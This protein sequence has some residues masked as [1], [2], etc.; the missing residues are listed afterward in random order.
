MAGKAKPQG[1]SAAKTTDGFISRKATEEDDVQGHVFHRSRDVVSMK[2]KVV[3]PEGATA[4]RKATEDDDTEGHS[5]LL[6]PTIAHELAKARERDIQK[7]L[8]QH[9]FERD[10]R[11]AKKD[12]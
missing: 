6:H 2:R 11:A 4:R 12:Q 8:K 1:F 3:E 9:R 5:L 10:A 7:D